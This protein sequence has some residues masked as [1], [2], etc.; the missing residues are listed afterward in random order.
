MLSGTDG[1]DFIRF[2][3]GQTLL[4]SGKNHKTKKNPTIFHP[5]YQPNAPVSVKV[6]TSLG[7]VKAKIKLKNQH[8]AVAK[9]IPRSRTYNDKASENK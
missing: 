2:F 4:V 6:L 1:E 8:V 5:A 7:Q 9:T 3:Q